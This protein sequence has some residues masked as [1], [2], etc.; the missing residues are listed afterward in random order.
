MFKELSAQDFHKVGHL[1]GPQKQYT[2][3]HA[4]IN[5]NYPG[6]VFVD[7][8]SSPKTAVVWSFSRWAYIEGDYN[9]PQFKLSIINFIKNIIIPDS[10]KL[11]INWF[12]LY[13]NN[14][15]VAISILSDALSNFNCTFHYES[16]YELNKSKYRS[17]RSNYQYPEGLITEKIDMPLIS[18]KFK[19]S[20]FV[21]DQFKSQFTVAFAL[22]SGDK[23]LSQCISNG[24]VKDNDFMVGVDTFDQGNRC[25]GYA[26]AVSVSLLDYCLEND[27]NPLWETTEDNIASQRLAEKLGY[28][29]G[30]IY[31][32]YGIEF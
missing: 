13:A 26:T 3:V 12:E 2:P 19:E 1:F 29:K 24:F 16:T 27:L 25:K 31:P 28:V 21:S 23:I 18:S 20:P 5:G 11:D 8:T 32:V 14:L 15:P 4:I 7:N 10:G 22:K 17:F 6:R 30:E 9:N